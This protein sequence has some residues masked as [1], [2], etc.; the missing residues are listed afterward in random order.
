V[1]GANGAGKS[2]LLKLAAGVLEPWAGRVSGVGDAV[3]C[4]Q[5]TD[6]M[7]EGLS[8]FLAEEEGGAR[9]LQGR[10]G[11][12]SDWP[13]RWDTLSHG[14]RKRAQIA[15]ALWME[16]ELLAVDEPT[17]H[18]DI[19]SRS[20]LASA[21]GEWRNVGILV[22]HD[23]ELLDGLC[24]QCLFLEPGAIVMR[25]GGYTRGAEQAA[26]ERRA[27]REEALR[28][29]REA[30]RLRR[31]A[32]R[33]RSRASAADRR[34]SKKHLSRK[35]ADGREKLDRAR[36]TGKDGSD[37]RLLRQLNGR[38]RRLELQAR[39]LRT[40]KEPALKFWLTGSTS[41]RD[42]VLSLPPGKLNLGGRR[43]LAWPELSL[44]PVDRVALTG[45]NGAGK[46]TLL[47]FMVAAADLDAEKLVYLPQEIPLE[48]SQ[49]ILASA[50]AQPRA[51]LGHLM[52]VVSGLGSDPEAL[53]RT[54]VPSPGETR[55][56]LLA[57]G[58]TRRPHLIVMDEPTNHLDLP[59]IELLERA[60]TTCPCAL[61]LVSH[62]RRFL[63]SVTRR[64]WEIHALNGEEL[65]LRE[66]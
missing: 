11:I 36:V 25:P 39:Q 47:R 32:A 51:E 61:L 50:R 59:S 54:P 9:R 43:T 17:N 22:S 55:K 57:L 15:L 23:R 63:I 49:Q 38:L 33:R 19:F 41:R 2:T 62:D 14:E 20:L 52:T 16:P 10:L 46:S 8:R 18:L 45:A 13:S 65:A 4:P 30:E 6:S 44:R 21:L 29:R 48:R 3:Y 42:H 12:A 1:V 24:R 66:V 60:L 40:A 34:R 37:G 64:S 27:A 5:R 58:V 53:L 31:E 7:P 56:L 35:D 28:T 26:G